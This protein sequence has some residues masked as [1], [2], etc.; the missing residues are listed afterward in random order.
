MENKKVKKPKSKVRKIIE[1]IGTGILGAVFLFA[2]VCNVSKWITA[3][4]NEYGKGDAFGFSSYIVLTDSMEPLYP[5]DSAI[6]THKDKPQDIVDAFNEIKDLNL[7]KLDEK[8]INLTFVDAYD[9]KV[10]S[11]YAQYNQ[12]TPITSNLATKEYVVMTHQLFEVRVNENVEEGNGRY[13]FFVH[14]INTEGHLSGEGQY[15]VFTEHELLGVVKMKSNF[16]GGVS[17][18][19]SSLWGLFI[20]LLIPCLY[21][22]ITSVLDIF[23]AYHSDDDEEELAAEGANGAAT[24]GNNIENMSQEDYEKLKQEMIN[25]M[26]NGKDSKGKNE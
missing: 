19:L 8:N 22:V 1:W 3:N 25:E 4:N 13:L 9:K 24:G 20:C 11:N 17:G 7:D 2:S 26:L 6:I 21:I 10:T 23:K 18:F 14:G 16:I 12:Q 5:V 15:Q